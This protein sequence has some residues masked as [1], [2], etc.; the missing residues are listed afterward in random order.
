MN[1]SGLLQ[2]Q[3]QVIQPQRVH[4]RGLAHHGHDHT[5]ADVGHGVEGLVQL[6]VVGGVEAAAVVADADDVRVVAEDQAYVHVVGAVVLG[7]AVGDD[8]QGHLLDAQA[9]QGR[10]AVV[11]AAGHAEIADSAGD[12]HAVGL[13]L[14]DPL[15]DLVRRGAEVIIQQAVGLGRDG[16]ALLAAPDED[17]NDQQGQRLSANETQPDAVDAEEPAEQQGEKG[18]HAEVLQPGDQLGKMDASDPQV[19]ILERSVES[20][21]QQC[22]GEEAHAADGQFFRVHIAAQ[23]QG[24]QRPCRHQHD[25]GQRQAE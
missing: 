19:I 16:H 6:Q 13:V 4:V 20:R 22:Q 1:E 21:G 3:R 8:V 12:V 2:N 9:D 5:D 23:E 7:E 11:Q 25:D 17:R 14:H 15:E 10:G 18:R 24:D